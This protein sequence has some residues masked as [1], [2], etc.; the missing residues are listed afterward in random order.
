MRIAFLITAY[1]NFKHLKLLIDALNNGQADFYIHVDSKSQFNTK[2]FDYA[3]VHFIKRIPV[4]WGGWSH[5]QAILNLMLTAYKNK[6][7]RYVLIS[8]T[9]Y[10]IRPNSFLFNKLEKRVEYL[11][12]IKGFQTHKPEKR[13]RYYYFDGFDRRNLKLLKTKCY[14]KLERLLRRFFIKRKYPFNTIYHG[15]TWWALSHEAINYILKFVDENPKFVKFFKTSWCPEES[16]IPTILGNSK[17]KDDCVGNLTY[18][19][20]SK[21]PSPAFLDEQHVEMFQQQHTFESPYGNYTPFFARK[22]SDN[23]MHLIDIIEQNLR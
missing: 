1:N 13:I 14:L 2:G 15:T 18:S 23:S 9:D 5:Q 16:F 20:W 17:F 10:P 11:N 21:K 3:N 6:Y 19:D 4:S 7:D 8:G 22:F 12:L